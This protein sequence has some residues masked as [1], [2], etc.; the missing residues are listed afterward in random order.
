MIRHIVTCKDIKGRA[1]YPIYLYKFL[2]DKNIIASLAKHNIQVLKIVS[3]TQS[4]ELK[5]AS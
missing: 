2:E 5:K 3:L 4:Q 1:I